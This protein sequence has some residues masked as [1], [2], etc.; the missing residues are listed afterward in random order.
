VLDVVLT[1]HEFVLRDSV[2][3]FRDMVTGTVQHILRSLE[4]SAIISFRLVEEAV[5]LAERAVSELQQREVALEQE[6]ERYTAEF[7]TALS[8]VTRHIRGLDAYVGAELTDWM[9]GQCMGPAAAAQLPGEIRNVLRSIVTAAVNI[10]SGGVLSVLGTALASIADLIDASAEA[11]RL[12]ASSPEGG[13]SGS[14]R[15]SRHSPRVTACP[16]SSSRLASTSRTRSCRSFSRA[17]IL[18]LHASRSRRG[19]CRRSS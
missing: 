19:P 12:T 2:N 17:S 16:T 8:D 4:L 7:F 14:S 3:L 6:A 18:R 11:L 10:S 9:I 13:L 1:S 15:C 5:E